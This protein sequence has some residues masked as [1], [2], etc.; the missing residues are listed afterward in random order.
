MFTP[1][2]P[3]PPTLSFAPHARPLKTPQSEHHQLIAPQRSQF[4]VIAD[5]AVATRSGIRLALRECRIDLRLCRSG[6]RDAAKLISAPKRRSP[7]RPRRGQKPPFRNDR[8]APVAPIVADKT[9]RSSAGVA[10]FLRRSVRTVKNPDRYA[11]AICIRV[12]PNCLFRG[13]CRRNQ[14]LSVLR[15][16]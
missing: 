1:E 6:R 7:R 4:C 5:T 16:A 2:C 10:T 12:R 3:T 9:A 11:A 13:L 15:R 8:S 14:R